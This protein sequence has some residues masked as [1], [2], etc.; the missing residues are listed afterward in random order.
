MGVKIN[1]TVNK[2]L[3]YQKNKTV[4]EIVFI[5]IYTKEKEIE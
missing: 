5:I 4:F 1:E 3:K 2:N